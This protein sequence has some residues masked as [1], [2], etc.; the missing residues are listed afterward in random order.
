MSQ[1]LGQFSRAEL[2]RSTGATGKLCEFDIH[3]V[4]LLSVIPE[5]MV[6]FTPEFSRSQREIMHSLFSKGE[7]RSQI[8]ISGIVSL[9]HFAGLEKTL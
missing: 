9:Q 6:Y 7:L 8:H 5:T 3:L 4:F 2:C 1:D